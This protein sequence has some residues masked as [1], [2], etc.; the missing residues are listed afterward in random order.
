MRP[1]RDGAHEVDDDIADLCGLGRVWEVADEVAKLRLE[2]GE[3]LGCG[4]GQVGG[5]H[6]VAEAAGGRRSCQ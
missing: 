6:V 5:G 4:R 3:I 1:G 2:D